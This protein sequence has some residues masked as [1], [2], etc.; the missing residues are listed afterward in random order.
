MAR[1]FTLPDYFSNT[2]FKFLYKRYGNHKYGIRL[3]AL[4]YLKCG[5]TLEKTGSLLLK[6]V[7]TLKDWVKLFGKRRIWSIAEYTHR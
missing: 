7:N 5:E 4:H 1:Y 6:S 3:L 2:D